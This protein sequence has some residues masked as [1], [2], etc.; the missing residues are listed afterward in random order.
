MMSVPTVLRGVLLWCVGVVL[1]GGCACRP[2]MIGETPANIR[3]ALVH[4]APRPGD[5]TLNRR[6]I[7]QAIAAAVSAKA[8][9]IVTPE[10]AETGYSFARKI[11]TDWIEPFP[12][13]WIHAM[14]GVARKNRVALFLGVAEK[15]KATGKLHNSV[16]VIDRQGVILGAYRKHRVVNGPSERWAQPGQET[17]LFTIDGIPVGILICADSYK[18]EIAA[19]EKMLGARI[20]LSP[21]NWPPAGEMGP[22]GY[23]EARTVETGLPLI[24]NNRTGSEPDIDFSAGESTVVLGGQRILT[25]TSPDTRVFLVDWD[26]RSGRFSS[27]GSLDIRKF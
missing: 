22:N 4:L 8:D 11:G 1:L 14:A 17:P 13:S 21:A 3:I 2:D 12:S 9:W 26:H 15:D 6:E 5:T 7:E 10:L 18:P 27:A 20:L 16:A 24:V 25:F 19:Q 23:W